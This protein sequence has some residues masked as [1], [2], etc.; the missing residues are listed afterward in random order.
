MR[1]DFPITAP[2]NIFER[3]P[4]RRGSKVVDPSRRG[5]V[6]RRGSVKRGSIS[7]EQEDQLES[8]KLKAALEAMGM[9]KKK[10]KEFTWDSVNST[11]RKEPGDTKVKSAASQ[12]TKDQAL[13]TLGLAHTQTKGKVSK[14]KT[15]TD[16]SEGEI[17]TA[18]Q[19]ECKSLSNY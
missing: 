7:W 17:L 6:T 2:W 1:N 19:K 10:Q 15:V 5:E 9:V 11:S 3:F 18:F 13:K 16:Y 12:M 4:C 14:P 8:K